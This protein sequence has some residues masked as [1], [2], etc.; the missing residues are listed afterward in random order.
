MMRRDT[1]L[2][3][4]LNL[5]V[6]YGS[7]QVLQNLSLSVA[8]G[9]I[10]GLVGESGSGKTTL[11]K[12]ILA[13]NDT[14]M[15]TTASAMFFAG[16]NLRTLGDIALRQLRGTDIGMV[17]QNAEASLCPVRTIGAQVVELM[18]NHTRMKKSEIYQLCMAHFMALRLENPEVLWCCYP[19]EL[20]GGMNQRVVIAMA[21]MLGPSLLLADEPTAALDTTS[22]AQVMRE[23]QLLSKERNLSMLIA[24]HDIGFLSAIAARIAVLYDGEIVE[25]GETERVLLHPKHMYTKALLEAVPRRDILCKTQL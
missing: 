19:S 2:L 4:I 14:D 25:F 17:F 21:V 7:K 9:E 20:S 1:A 8:H 16:Q 5:N 22:Q 18:R 12:A 6:Y 13:L 10:I 23:L 15:K 11:L 3:S 24:S